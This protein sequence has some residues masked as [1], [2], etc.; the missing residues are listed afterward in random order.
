MVSITEAIGP[1]IGLSR[2]EIDAELIR[3]RSHQRRTSV[4]SIGSDLQ[5]VNRST[6]EHG[7]SYNSNDND[8][9]RLRDFDPQ[10][11]NGRWPCFCCCC[12]RGSDEETDRLIKDDNQDDRRT[13]SQQNSNN[14]DSQ[15]PHDISHSVDGHQSGES[16]YSTTNPTHSI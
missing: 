3:S 14:Q 2:E 7:R 4:S 1:L 12:G 6:Q 9:D 13:G 10:I 16:G 11:Q 5:T 15:H 8:S